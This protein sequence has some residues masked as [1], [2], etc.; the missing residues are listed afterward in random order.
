MMIASSI[1]E[2]CVTL[3]IPAPIQ[4]IRSIPDALRKRRE[5]L[6]EE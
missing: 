6:G 2:I 3:I 5:V 1:E 4:D